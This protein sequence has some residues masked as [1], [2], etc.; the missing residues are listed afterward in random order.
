MIV[1][2]LSD[3]HGGR[4]PSAK[5]KEDKVAAGIAELM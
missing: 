4:F 1:K 3:A 5:Y 2:K